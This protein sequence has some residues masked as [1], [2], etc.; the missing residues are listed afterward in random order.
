MHLIRVI[1]GHKWENRYRNFYFAIHISILGRFNR[2]NKKKSVI[3]TLKELTTISMTL[4]SQKL[5]KIVID[6]KLNII[7]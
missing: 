4:K 7:V 3:Y 1:S 5:Y 2:A 6:P